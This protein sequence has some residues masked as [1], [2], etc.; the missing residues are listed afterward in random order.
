MN[1][2]VLLIDGDSA[3]RERLSE[4]LGRY[5]VLVMTEADPERALGIAAA[6]PP[7]LLVIA[8]EEPEKL[9]FKI[10][11]KA[12]KAVPAK[13]PIMLVSSTLP[14]ESFA[15][16][17]S[18]KLRADEYV[19]KRSVDGATLVQKIDALIALGEPDD[20]LPIGE[21]IPM[22]LADGDVVLDEQFDD[23]DVGSF[24]QDDRHDM[25]TI[26]PN[27]EVLVDRM[28]AQ[29]TDAA[30]DA[31][32]GDDMF[33]GGGDPVAPEPAATMVDSASAAPEAESVPEPVPEPIDAA[34]EAIEAAEDSGIPEPVPHKIPDEIDVDSV[35][36]PI[37]DGG[38]ETGDDFDSY[39]KLAAKNVPAEVAA[40]A[41]PVRSPIERMPSG[42]D[43]DFAEEE[44]P[45][46]TDDIYATD[47]A[48]VL[49]T[50][51]EPEAAPV[52]AI[53]DEAAAVA[54]EV[55]V[56]H[57]AAP[58]ATDDDAPVADEEAAGLSSQDSLSAIPIVDDDLV[59][60]DDEMVEV[61]DELAPESDAAE[62]VVTAPP[63]RRSSSTAAP[64]PP[65]AKTPTAVPVV[66][67]RA[68]T[69]TAAPEPIKAATSDRTRAPAVDLGLDS[70]AQNV[71][72]EREQSGVY[73]H[74]GLRKIGELE[75]QIA[76]LKTELDRAR[77][78]ADAAAKGNREAQFL[79]L[80]EQNLARE[81]E[82]KELKKSVETQASELAEATEKLRQA[83]HAKDKLQKQNEQLEQKIFESREREL[84]E[85]LKEMNATLAT[86]ERD[87]EAK[88]KAALATE[89]ALARLE[90]DLATERANRAASASEAEQNLRSEREQL[91]Q[92][93][94]AELAAL[95]AEA[96]AAQEQAL[97][98]TREELE[99]A[100]AAKLDETIEELR[101]AN[102]QEHHEAVEALE[103]KH[104]SELANLKAAQTGD[105]QEHHKT[106]EALE[107]KYSSELV[108]LKAEQAGEL[109]RVRTE[110]GSKLAETEGQLRGRIGEL[111]EQL[112]AAGQS[113]VAAIAGAEQAQARAVAELEQKYQGELAQAAR[114]AAE[115]AAHHKVEAAEAARAA[116]EREAAL[117]AQLEQ[118]KAKYEAE[119]EARDEEANEARE[120]DA[121]SHG[122]AIAQLK[123]QLDRAIAG[124]EAKIAA[125]QRE[126]GELGTQHEAATADL[127]SRHEAA[128]AELRAKHEADL[129][130][131]GDG[132]KHAAEAHRA[133]LAEQQSTY[134]ARL[135]EASEAAQREIVEQRAQVHAMTKA[136]EDAA[137]RHAAEREEMQQA[138]A[139][140]IGEL[141]AKH[142]RAIAVINGEALKAKAI[143][144]AEHGKQIAALEAE[145]TR[146]LRELEETHARTVSDL[147]GERD[148]LKKGLSGARDSLKRSESE[149]ASAVQTIA[150]R[151][152]D[153]RAHA[154]AIAERDQRIA[155][156]RAEIESLEGE[157]TNYQE[158]VL[159][160]YQKIKTDEAMVARARKAMAIALTVLDDQGNP[161]PTKS[162]T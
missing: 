133:A 43:D 94:Q 76:Q 31:L 28:V 148:E 139:S 65:R 52:A 75:R 10:F 83:Q 116:G 128:I 73:D 125:A 44:A 147:V 161:T 155:E 34:P 140:A 47:A 66:E 60:M 30:F 149:L 16:H 82:L 146:K 3:F 48:P 104:S 45:I 19:D 29:E 158:Q 67:P 123:S 68:K 117:T 6:D 144:D 162:E 50:S 58:F 130:Q 37:L 13:L 26:N 51:D 159:R 5:R 40:H 141:E 142:E 78:N 115:L 12:R 129:G 111:E 100:H 2:R 81:G 98:R 36:A 86:L 103:A 131:L 46:S 59:S 7:D 153:L 145:A 23:D 112:A 127:V 126:L 20:D 95:K 136:A 135:A 138:S 74:K 21:D 14:P 154:A 42:H 41:E 25:A 87:L 134:E 9:G 151:N 110:L 124:H 55:P 62:A 118:T 84:E 113:H 106:V 69:P 114:A 99:A 39:S 121:E 27:S 122:Q 89:T 8:V 108:S 17:R 4:E 109:S 77:T 54:D 119:I 32:L 85:M 132:A 18:M 102:A 64:P 15:K 70:I 88:A 38:R 33:G 105:A 93:Y 152:A 63:Q 143:A 22:E 11:Q 101:R 71:E 160:A 24:A 92:R 56:E 156:L 90:R 150:D 80:R 72:A 96:D 49:A 120:R 1:R 137:A 157:N 107:A 61:E 57:E 91:V 53:A 97:V 79:N 35:P